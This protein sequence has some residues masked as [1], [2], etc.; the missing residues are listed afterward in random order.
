MYTPTPRIPLRAALPTALLFALCTAPR[1]AA[2]AQTLPPPAHQQLARAIFKELIEINTTQAGGNTRI[3]EALAARFRAAGFPDADVQIVGPAPG[4]ENL[5][6]R[7]RGK[8]RGKPIL[9]VAHL[10]VVDARPEDWSLPPFELTERE[11]YF[12]GRGTSDNKDAVAVLVANLLRLKGERYTPERDLILALTADEEVTSN[13]N[14][15][16]WLLQ[17]RR[18][19]IDAE[20]ALNP[21]GGGADSRGGKREQLLVQTSEKVYLTFQ[22]EVTN[23]GGHSSLPVPENAIYRLANGLARLSRLEFPVRLNTTTRGYFQRM[24]EREAGTTRAD[25]LALLDP[26]PDPAAAARLAGTPFYNATLRTTCVATMLD[27]GHAENALPQ[28]ARATVQCR[29]LPGESP[30]EVRETVRRAL[31]DDQIAVTPLWEV[32]PSP[33]TPPPPAVMQAVESV[34]RE[35]WPGVAVLPFMSTGA[36]DGLYLRRA[37]VPVYGVSGLFLD[38]DDVRAHG[39][40]ERIEVRSFYEATEFMYRLMKRL[41]GGK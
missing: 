18:D 12:Y 14:G 16:D 31:A 9:F 8:G 32:R 29:L 24:A 22:L 5:V 17:H 1:Q 4:K 39:R 41:G 3:T 20:Y 25:M 34:T 36:T 13:T 40:D 23:P 15:V 30:E 10:D 19:L 2:E 7:Y 33:E 6:V 28:R 11:G 21:D 37:G 26:T 27:A 35:L 38:V